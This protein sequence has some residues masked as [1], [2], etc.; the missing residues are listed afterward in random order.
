MSVELDLEIHGDRTTKKKVILT[1][2]AH[3][4]LPTQISNTHFTPIYNLKMI[5]LQPHHNW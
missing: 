4:S 3:T 5:D 1:S 2:K